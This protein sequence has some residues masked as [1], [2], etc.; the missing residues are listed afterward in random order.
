MTW[1]WHSPEPIANYLV[2]NSIG[3]YDLAARTSPTSGIQYFTAIASGLTA[4]RKTA[5]KANIE[6]H[7]DF[8]E[9]QKI[10]NGPYPFS[11]AGIVVAQ[12]SV[13]F[14]EE[15]QTKITFGNGATSTPSL[16]TIAHE[17]MH[18]WFGDN[19]AEGSFEMTFWKEGWATVGEYLNTARTAANAAGGLGTLAGQQA[20]DTSLINRFNG[21]GNYGT[22]SSTFWNSA[23]SDPTVINLFTTSRTYTRPATAYLALRQIL[24]ASATRPASDRW[25]QAMK[26][27]QSTYGG[28]SITEQQLEN[29]FHQVLP[30]QSAACSTKL[31][32]FF[33]QWF[34]TPYPAP[35]IPANKPQITGPG[36]NGPDHF[37]DN[38]TACTKASQTITFGS[39]ADK[40][41]TDPDFTVSATSDS[42]L[43][44]SFGAAG[45]CTV[46]GT[47]VDLTGPGDCTITASQAGDGVFNPATD[48]P[49]AFKIAD[50]TTLNVASASGPYG[51][52]AS[53][54]ATLIASG[55]PVPNESVSFSLNG[56]S[57]GSALTDGSGVANIPNASLAGI[58][59]GSY[60][61]GVSASF[62]GDD[63]LF[64]G[65]SGTGALT[66]NPADQTID[67]AA[68]PDKEFGDPDFQVSATATSTLPVTF[69][70]AGQCTNTGDMV[71]ITA[72][73][74][75]TVT[76]H[77]AGDSNYNAAPDVARS[78]TINKGQQTITF[79]AQPHRTWGDPNSGII[80]ASASSGLP[81]T[82]SK[83]IGKCSVSPAGVVHFN[84]AGTCVVAAHQGGNDNWLPAPT[85]Q[86]SVV[87][88]RADQ[89]INFPQPPDKTFGDPD[90][91]LIATSSSGL[92]VKF[93]KVSG[94]C[95][96]T[97]AGLVHLVG[98]GTCSVKATQGGNKNYN[99]APTVVRSFDI[100]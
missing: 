21:T 97:R 90:F 93:G 6:Q 9:F 29:V 73:G 38:A 82:F 59:A 22:T 35:N 14:A 100:N 4:T 3:S 37:Y 53:V 69:T 45:P 34:D 68:L 74:S 63:S 99:A 31:D 55:N 8:V 17:N 7:E 20:F 95:K 1:H 92:T 26:L 91:N 15:M 66:V 61:T 57:V 47:T 36:I 32:E 58:N 13:G 79:P 30:N 81:L 42:G 5:I 54:S 86:Q 51:G 64:T 48:V 56:N 46:T 33:R 80:G 25:I 44:V 52:T 76:A 87:M 62:A 43:P 19:V 23:P 78:F 60:P 89:T 27:I 16:G 49:Q 24:D 12:P 88:D 41:K 70:T 39:L 72:A 84:Q 28:G 2:E 50:T 18:Q 11:T 71:H 77:Q 83:V 65:S 67:F 75:C 85:V 98:P 94:P 96:V 40:V 10:F